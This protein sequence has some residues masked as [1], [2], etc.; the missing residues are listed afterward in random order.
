MFRKIESKIP[1]SFNVFRNVSIISLI[2]ILLLSLFAIFSPIPKQLHKSRV[3]VGKQVWAF[4]SGNYGNIL[5]DGQWKTWPTNSLSSKSYSDIKEPPI[6]LNQQLYPALGLYSSHDPSVLKTHLLW[7]HQAGI[8]VLIFEWWGESVTNES[9]NTNNTNNYHNF[10]SKKDGFSD[11]TLK[12]LLEYAPEYHIKITPFIMNYE[13]QHSRSSQSFYDDAIYLWNNYA[14]NPSILHLFD[15]PVFG[16]F[17]PNS[18]HNIFSSFQKLKSKGIEPFWF[19]SY[20]SPKDVGSLVEE[21]FHAL[22]TYSPVDEATEASNSSLWTSYALDFKQRGLLFI[23]T[24]APGANLPRN[25]FIFH[26]FDKKRLRKN[27]QYY[28]YMWEV[29]LKVK[30]DVIAI[31]SFNSW[32]EASNIE[33]PID[34]D[35]YR[36]NDDTWDNSSDPEFYLKRTK[37]WIDH[38]KGFA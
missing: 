31:A 23:P 4:Y 24:V 14:S 11:M 21:G 25:I 22:L 10:Y 12:M 8:D 18:I 27:S 34:R 17:D 28:D 13:D 38:Y 19:G 15:K 29:A 33:P 37:Y 36:L 3:K 7:A 32:K 6:P 20:L 26:D 9:N 2:I 16:V 1:I 30:T 35:G 5:S